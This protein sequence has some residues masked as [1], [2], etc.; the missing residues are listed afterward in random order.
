[1]RSYV[2]LESV[3][4]APLKYTVTATCRASAASLDNAV[5][6]HTLSRTYSRSLNRL[7]TDPKNRQALMPYSTPVLTLRDYLRSAPAV[8]S[9]G[10]EPAKCGFSAKGC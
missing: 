1:M 9:S 5:D 7:C 4:I 3:L 8:F 6:F 10:R 2:S